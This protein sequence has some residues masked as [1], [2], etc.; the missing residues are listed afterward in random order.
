M[1]RTA[2]RFSSTDNIRSLFL[3][4]TRSIILVVKLEGADFLLTADAGG[5]KTQSLNISS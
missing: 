2:T 5:R 3:K 4:G 1:R